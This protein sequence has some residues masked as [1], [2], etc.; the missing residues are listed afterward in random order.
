M[1]VQ[2]DELLGLST[3]IVAPRSH[4][5]AAATFRPEV[6]IEGQ[7]TRVLVEQLR[8]VT[9]IAST[10]T[11]VGSHLTSNARSTRRSNWS[12]RC[13]SDIRERHG[14]APIVTAG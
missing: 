2:A 9:W 4:S 12:S 14:G 6:A 1:I 8:A 10:V 3:A 5:A 7:A 11:Q 13:R